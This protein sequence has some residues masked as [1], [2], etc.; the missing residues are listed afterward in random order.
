MNEIYPNYI[1]L[2]NKEVKAK[3][4]YIK[5]VQ[6][7]FN[8][9]QDS[10]YAK[11]EAMEEAKKDWQNNYKKYKEYKTACDLFEKA[12]DTLKEKTDIINYFVDN[13][14]TY[15]IDYD[16]DKATEELKFVYDTYEAELQE[17]NKTIKD[18]V[19]TII[20]AKKRCIAIVSHYDKL[21]KKSESIRNG[22]PMIDNHDKSKPSSH[23]PTKYIIDDSVY[24]AVAKIKA[25]ITRFIV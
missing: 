21:I 10:F 23:L 13:S 19:A 14:E 20:E 4:E 1:N 7:E 3:N 18:S 5:G 25:G 15:D 17:I 12:K 9:A 2:Y 8:E 22:A 16:G 6:K 24:D 11:K